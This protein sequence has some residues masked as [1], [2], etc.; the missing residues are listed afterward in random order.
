LNKKKTDKA[1]PHSEHIKS[2][3]FLKPT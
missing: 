2:S 1:K 3:R